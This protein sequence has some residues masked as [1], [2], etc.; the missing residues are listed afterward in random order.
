MKSRYFTQS[1]LS[2]ESRKSYSKGIYDTVKDFSHI[3]VVVLSDKFGFSEDDIIK[4]TNEINKYFDEAND[5]RVSFSEIIEEV[6]S[7]ILKNH[8]H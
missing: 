2:K 1:E 4:F 7:S 6:S 5:D 3:C 8:Y